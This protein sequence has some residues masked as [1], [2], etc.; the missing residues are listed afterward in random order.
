MNTTLGIDLMEKSTLKKLI[1]GSILCSVLYAAPSFASAPTCEQVGKDLNRIQFKQYELKSGDNKTLL[2]LQK[3]YDKTLSDASIIQ[4]LYELNKKFFLVL[5]N[6]TSLLARPTD[7]A[8]LATQIQSVSS[9]ENLKVMKNMAAMDALI[10]ELANETGLEIESLAAG[11]NP[12]SESS[13]LNTYQRIALACQ[14]KQSVLC[15]SLTNESVDKNGN[16][17]PT[18]Q[19]LDSFMIAFAANSE[20]TAPAQRAEALANYRGVLRRGITDS[21]NFEELY[22]QASAVAARTNAEALSK[23]VEVQHN[24]SSERLNVI[25]LNRA[26]CCILTPQEAATSDS[27][28]ALANFDHNKCTGSSDSYMVQAAAV[29][30]PI[31]R[32]FLDYEQ[33]AYRALNFKFEDISSLDQTT[34]EA[35]RP[36]GG[37]LYL[38]RIGLFTSNFAPDMKGSIERFTNVMAA[39]LTSDQAKLRLV[40]NHSNNIVNQISSYYRRGRSQIS[41]NPGHNF[42]PPGA[43]ITTQAQLSDV[44]KQINEQICQISNSRTGATR[45]DC[46]SATI[47]SSRYVKVFE[48]PLRISLSSSN[49]LDEVFAGNEEEIEARWQHQSQH[50]R[51]KLNDLR[52]KIE[53]IKASQSYA[54]LDQLKSFMIWD[55]RNRCGISS[56]N[57]I[58]I[59]TCGTVDANPSVDYLIAQVGSVTNLLLAET[60]AAVNARA[61]LNNASLAERRVILGNM[62]G[63]CLGL[64]R[65]QSENAESNMTGNGISQ[66]C[67][68]IASMQ[69]AAQQTT[70]TERSARLERS[71]RYVD[72]EGRVRRNP[73]TG[74]DIALGALR[75]LGTSG[76]DLLGTYFQGRAISDS[77]PYQY[78]YY[79]GMK[80]NAYAQN[81]WQT[82]T[83]MF[84]SFPYGMGNVAPF[85]GTTG[86]YTSGFNFNTAG[87][88]SSP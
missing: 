44:T 48:N 3:E 13:V 88:V 82:N 47:Q 30:P 38:R 4:E 20:S 16:P 43:Q 58:S 32:T 9:S 80:L 5:N 11:F 14:G 65:M 12:Q 81:W 17:G 76:P 31:A 40:T 61:D 35:L 45:Q 10:T 34:P 57:E 1:A 66:A 70:P 28:K 51:T 68:R 2:E 77:A 41:S 56:N 21:A 85:Y 64:Q 46:T 49:A 69:S 8:A 83:P 74:R 29:I 25:A 50:V 60:D 73:S 33:S 52:Q 26:Q 53:G 75:G 63:A 37:N 19:L 54:Y 78:Q 18:R 86:G 24:G 71:G 39:N 59:P 79:T 36:F 42:M 62:N 6:P 27:C 22:N 55:M 84:P 72:T 87:L 23:L 7:Y 67:E 15:T